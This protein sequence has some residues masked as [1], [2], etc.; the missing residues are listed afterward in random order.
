M[1]ENFIGPFLRNDTDVQQHVG[2]LKSEDN[3][4]NIYL[5]YMYRFGMNEQLVHES[6]RYLKTGTVS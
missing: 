5:R 1:L 3:D 2:L 6:L 4:N